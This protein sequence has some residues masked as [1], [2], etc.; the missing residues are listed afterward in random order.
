[1]NQ[2]SMTIYSTGSL[3]QYINYKYIY[4]L[5]VNHY[6]IT[7]IWVF[8]IFK[9]RHPC[10]LFFPS[11]LSES[12]VQHIMLEDVGGSFKDH[13]PN[14]DEF[15]K[16]VDTLSFLPFPKTTLFCALKVR[17]CGS[18]MDYTASPI[19]SLVSRQAQ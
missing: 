11:Q 16:E 18:K 3:V 1:M 12:N 13:I 7:H 4:L 2:I 10:R 15:L 17:I 19:I 8:L 14:K 9:L 5:N 6:S